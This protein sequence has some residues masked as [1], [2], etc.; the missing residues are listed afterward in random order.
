MFG[1]RIFYWDTK[2]VSCFG[3]VLQAYCNVGVLITQ[4][5]YK[6]TCRAGS[7]EGRGL[8]S[9]QLERPEDK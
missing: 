5:C 7:N 9:S 8:A 6:H 2:Q 4:N 1:C 3:L